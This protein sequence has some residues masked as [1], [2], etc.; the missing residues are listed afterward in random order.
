MLAVSLLRFSLG[1]LLASLFMLLFSVYDD[2]VNGNLLGRA[3]T[4]HCHQIN[5]S[6]A[7]VL[8]LKEY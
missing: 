7:F 1:A 8:H 6:E 5:R 4:H 2:C 3:K